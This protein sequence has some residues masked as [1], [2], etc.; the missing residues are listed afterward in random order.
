V[1]IAGNTLENA[2]EVLNRM[3]NNPTE[4][5]KILMSGHTNFRID[6]SEEKDC[7]WHRNCD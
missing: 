1:C 5:D 7:W 4:N 6:F 2:K 3:L